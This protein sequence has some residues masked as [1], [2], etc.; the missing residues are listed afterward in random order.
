[1]LLIAG[2]IQPLT[3]QPRYYLLT[4]VRQPPRHISWFVPA[5][6]SRLARGPSPGSTARLSRLAGASLLTQLPPTPCPY[7]PRRLAHVPRSSRCR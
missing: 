7:S 2:L 6:R 1:M 5:A 3:Q 4:T